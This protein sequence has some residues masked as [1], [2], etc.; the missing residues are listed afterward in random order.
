MA[1]VIL[2]GRNPVL[3]ALRQGSRQIEEVALLHE[4]RGRLRELEALARQLGLKVSHRSRTELT[5]MAGH[6]H[7][8]GVVA[9]VA[10]KAYAELDD[11]LAIPRQRGEVPLFLALD[12][13]QDPQNLGSLLRTAE[14][15]GVHGV[16]LLRHH[17]A[18]LTPATAKAAAGALEFLPV[19]RVVNMVSALER[20]KAEGCWVIGA[21]PEGT[22]EAWTAD[23]ARPL[24]LVLG[25]EGRGLRP[26]VART[27]DL[28]VRIPLKG[29]VSS[30]NV[31]AAGAILLYEAVRQR[32]RGQ[33]KTLDKPDSD[34]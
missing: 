21:T 27:C 25:G 15:A 23:L 31:G 5:T 14:A 1:G 6:P 17:A 20:L 12:Q 19:G 8:Q 28:L 4:G 10:A 30:L 2:Y 3:E 9:R 18:G 24:T 13:V 34:Y 29:Q 32:R 7:H 26:L 16:I 11:L 33:G 22:E